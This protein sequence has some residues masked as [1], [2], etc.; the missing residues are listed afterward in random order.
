MGPRPSRR[1]EEERTEE[2]HREA[3]EEER[4]RGSMW[5]VRPLVKGRVAGTVDDIILVVDGRFVGKR[6]C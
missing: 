3:V 1:V 2:R 6:D 4:V 5:S